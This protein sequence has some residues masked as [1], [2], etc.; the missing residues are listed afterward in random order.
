MCHPDFLGDEGHNICV[1]LNEAYEVSWARANGL[2]R[3]VELGASQQVLTWL[4]IMVG[5]LF[6]THSRACLLMSRQVLSDEE[7]RVA[8][9]GKLEEALKDEEDDYT[10]GY[11]REMQSLFAI[12]LEGATPEDP[13]L[14]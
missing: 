6:S 2:R 5:I 9:N 4:L 8:Y 1:L 3:A 10:G 13:E 12:S 14:P 7:Q 11:T